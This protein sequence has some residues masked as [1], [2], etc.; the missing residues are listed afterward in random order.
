MK[1]IIPIE[2]KVNN[3]VNT[4]GNEHESYQSHSRLD[5]K[6]C[7]VLQVELACGTICEIM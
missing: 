4:I 6:K 5:K 3:N 2:L 1:K 7:F